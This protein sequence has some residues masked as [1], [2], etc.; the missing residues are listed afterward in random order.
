MISK[1]VGCEKK[2]YSLDVTRF[3]GDHE[4]YGNEIVVNEVHKL[5][6]TVTSPSL[7]KLLV[8]TW[9]LEK[10]A[11]ES[12]AS[13]EVINGEVKR[14][15]S[16]KGVLDDL[17]YTISKHAF[18]VDRHNPCSITLPESE[19]FLEIELLSQKELQSIYD[20][21]N[22]SSKNRT[23]RTLLRSRNTTV[24]GALAHRNKPSNTMGTL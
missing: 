9:C 2:G 22:P 14:I 15:Q 5:P 21:V 11:I 7:R 4:N 10:T 18:T 6:L 16:T 13:V 3:Y 19:G 12:I 24:W 8:Y 23:S 20:Y 1:V 17:A